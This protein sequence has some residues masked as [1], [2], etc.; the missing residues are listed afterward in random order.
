MCLWAVVSDGLHVCGDSTDFVEEECRAAS[1]TVGE[2]A[3]RSSRW[4]EQ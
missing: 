4:E 1:R 2:H 3:T